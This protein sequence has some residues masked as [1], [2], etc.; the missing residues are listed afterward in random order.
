MGQDD[1]GI[2]PYGN[3]APFERGGGREA[4]GLPR[5]ASFSRIDIILETPFSSIVTP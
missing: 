4:G 2:V 3:P 5:Y 1:V